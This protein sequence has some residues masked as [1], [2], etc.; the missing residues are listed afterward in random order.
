MS[1]SEVVLPAPPATLPNGKIDCEADP[2]PGGLVGARQQ[3]QLEHTRHAINT[4]PD[5]LKLERERREEIAHARELAEIRSEP[6][7]KS[8]AKP[9]SFASRNPEKR[10]TM[11]RAV[12]DAGKD[13]RLFCEFM[14]GAHISVP[15]AWGVGSW[16]AAWNR[17]ELR[18]AIRSFKRHH[19]SAA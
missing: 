2:D 13:N 11:A 18:S 3:E 4:L 10:A 9:S 1:K 8:Q 6:R 15:A 19:R 17:K 14:D 16:L 12:Q 7:A 5:V